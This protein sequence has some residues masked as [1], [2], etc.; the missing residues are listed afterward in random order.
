MTKIVKRFTF[1]DLILKLGDPYFENRLVNGQGPAL[2]Y[3]GFREKR[4]KGFVP[5]KR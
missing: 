4:L 2:P 5:I 3:L 1:G